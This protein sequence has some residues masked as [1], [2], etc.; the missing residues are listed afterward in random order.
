MTT[1]SID[2]HLVTVVGRHADILPNMLRHYRD[3]G[4][5]SFDIH[6]HASDPEDSNISR[7]KGIARQY[8]A[9]IAS[10]TIAPWS[11]CINPML[12][13]VSRRR[14]P[15]DWFI[16]ADQDEFQQYPRPLSE[17]VRYCVD[18]GYDYVEGCVI[19]RVATSGKLEPVSPDISLA[20]QFPVGTLISGAL[21]GS[22]INKIVLCKGAVDVGPGQH[23]AYSGK[24]CPACELYIPVFHYKWTA[25][26]M[27]RLECR[28][29]EQRSLGEGLWR[30]NARF[31]KHYQQYGHI[32]LQEPAFQA[33]LC[34]PDYPHWSRVVEYRIASQFFRKSLPFVIR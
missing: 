29:T 30:E 28:I 27:K 7:I 10:L 9:E 6:V 3:L 22:V 8:G 25:D 15:A 24:G 19:D 16:M 12:H 32:Q 21:L 23:F 11:E 26:L 1:D 5:E 14:H 20:E 31:L 33:G 2:I 13:R 18:H 34:N 17:V 4:V